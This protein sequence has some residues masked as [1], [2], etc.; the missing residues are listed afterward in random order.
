MIDNLTVLLTA[1]LVKD[2]THDGHHELDTSA[3]SAIAHIQMHF[4]LRTKTDAKTKK[5]ILN[6]VYIHTQTLWPFV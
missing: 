3:P 6:T 5:N 4:Q 1:R 2:M